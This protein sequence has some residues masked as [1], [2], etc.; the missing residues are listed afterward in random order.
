M[1]KNIRT[2]FLILKNEIKGKKLI[3]LDS[4]ST[5]QKPQIVIES[6]RSFYEKSNANV[7]RGIYHLSEQATQLYEQARAKIAHFINAK[8]PSEIIFTRGTTESINLVAATWGSENIKEGDEIVIT[9]LEHHSN[10]LPWL[11][12]VKKNKAHLKYIPVLSDGRIDIDQVQHIITQKTQLVSIIHVSN[13]IGVHVPI[14]DII[15][16]AHE[17]GARVLIDAAQSIAHQPIDVQKMDCD[18]LAFSGHKL[19]GPTGIG[20]L[21]IKKE[22]HEQIAPYQFGGSMVYEADFQHATWRTMPH[23]LEAGTP[24][25]AQAVGLG[26]AIDYIKAAID[27]HTLRIHEASL[28]SR[29][30][31]G[32]SSI[33][34]ISIIGPIAEL[35]KVGHMVSFTIK[36]I[37]PHDV[38]AYLDQFGICV[39]AGHQCAQPLAKKLGIDSSIRVSFSAYNT[40]EEVDELLN[41]LRELDK[42][43]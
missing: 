5:T 31:D 1:K 7:H 2:D 27:W 9:E 6:E 24:A 16:L 40:V 30:I 4:A 12:L 3:Y 21:Y 41:V 17:R 8:D 34:S 10:L 19:F 37:H 22:L 20:V 38:A 11:N 23:R 32:L 33:P 35:K 28:C 18:F 26:V 15:D 42:T 13:A 36:G 29:F 43:I 14:K 25:I 39:R